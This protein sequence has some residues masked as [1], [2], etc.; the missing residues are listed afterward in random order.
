MID[1]VVIQYAFFLAG[2]ACFVAGTMIGLIE[3]L[4]K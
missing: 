3:H 4:M 2:S 1:L